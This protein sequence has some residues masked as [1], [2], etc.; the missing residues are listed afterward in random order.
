MKRYGKTLADIDTEKMIQ[1][2]Q[3]ILEILNFGVDE[4]QKIQI[5]KLL[6]CELEDI[7]MMKSIVNIV[8]DKSSDDENL[9]KDLIIT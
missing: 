6:A 8:K 5:I 7:N 4:T 3:I 2:R 1:C 9:N